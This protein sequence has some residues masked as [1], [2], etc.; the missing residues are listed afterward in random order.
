MLKLSALMMELV[1]VVCKKTHTKVNQK[2]HF[3]S[4]K[5]ERTTVWTL[6][7]GSQ[8]SLKGQRRDVL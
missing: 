6:R 4:E 8:G 7:A 2:G 5:I 3:I 1:D